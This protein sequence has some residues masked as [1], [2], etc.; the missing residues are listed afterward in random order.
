METKMNLKSEL[1]AR[2][3]EKAKSKKKSRQQTI[4]TL[5]VLVIGEC[6]AYFIKVN[7]PQYGPTY[8]TVV[9]SLF[10]VLFALSIWIFPIG[11]VKGAKKAFKSILKTELSVCPNLI[12]L[13]KEEVLSAEENLKEK[14]AEL[15][16]LEKNYINLKEI[17]KEELGQK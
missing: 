12:T 9:L 6:G 8:P 3:V 13:K 16:K 5:S 2:A 1:L 10:L 7:H 4:L 17:E 15:E 11:K 14:Q